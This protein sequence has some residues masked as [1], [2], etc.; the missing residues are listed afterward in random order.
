MISQANQR[1]DTFEKPSV[2]VISIDSMSRGNFIRQMAQTRKY[3]LDHLQAFEM[4]AYNKVGDNTI[5]NMGPV[6][7]GKYYAELEEICS[8]ENVS[9][10][11]S[12]MDDF[13]ER[14][15]RIT[16]AE[17]SFNFLP[18]CITNNHVIDY[19]TYNVFMQIK[20]YPEIVTQEFCLGSIQ[21]TEFIL[22]YLKR[23]AIQF[24]K[25]PTFVLSHLTYL[26]HDDLNGA[27]FADA[28]YVRFLTELKL[29]GIFNNTILIM[30]GDHGYRVGAFRHTFIGN[31]E[32]KLP[33]FSIAV[34]EWFR[35]KY[36]TAVKNL[37]INYRRLTSNFDVHAT[38][39]EIARLQ[40]DDQFKK[41]GKLNQRG[42]SMF[43]EIPKER[44][45]DHAT[46]LAH[47]CTCMSHAPVSVNDTT[48]KIVTD[49]VIKTLNNKLSVFRR[50][51][52]LTLKHIIK[53]EILSTT[54]I[55]F[56]GRKETIY[57]VEFVT[58]LGNARFE[59]T[60]HYTNPRVIELQA[61]VSR[62]NLYG[63]QSDC[64]P[65]SSLKKFCYCK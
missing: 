2:M 32:E 28:N 22:D 7:S 54:N 34:P 51:A 50:C 62:L 21:H 4:T 23:F 12:V 59:A 35:K 10:Y 48:V 11:R 53:A 38:L 63:S 24:K 65:I 52:N 46:I 1:K 60:V 40:S 58:V 27:S 14:G 8:R 26:T 45:C 49:F 61:D 17:D 33:Y 13:S 25:V 16:H 44:T 55:Q 56:K 29:K 30:M 41:I 19:S 20:R 31:L 42:I 5:R 43:H 6:Y 47:W 9:H 15:Y 57:Q 18:R 37:N 3:L 64:V 39:Q 36:P